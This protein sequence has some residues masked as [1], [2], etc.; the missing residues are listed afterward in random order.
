MGIG[1]FL[2][3][4]DGLRELRF[5][6]LIGQLGV[7]ITAAV[8]AVRAV[9]WRVVY[10]DVPA[11]YAVD[12]AAPPPELKP[13]ARLDDDAWVEVTVSDASSGQIAFYLLHD[14]PPMLL[15]LFM[16]GML[17]R[18]VT[19]AATGHPFTASVSR[20]LSVLGLVLL[21]GGTLVALAQLAAS[22]YLID[23]ISTLP[24]FWMEPNWVWWLAGSG[25]VAA[26]EV[27]RRGTEMRAE[28]DEVI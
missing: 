14:W 22:G 20:H 27:V 1:A 5:V 21:A 8:V 13:K 18:A 2:R 24:A 12:L 17:Y 7:A 23:S 9:V 19:R 11:L 3:R 10:V 15:G 25:F 26:G 16:L 28:L 6:L 4:A